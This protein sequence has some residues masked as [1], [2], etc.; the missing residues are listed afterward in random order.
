MLIWQMCYWLLIL[1][2][3]QSSQLQVDHK[4]LFPTLVTNES[5]T[6]MY[7]LI[8]CM[9]ISGYIPNVNGIV[10]H[11]FIYDQNPE[12]IF[13]YKPRVYRLLMLPNV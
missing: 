2:P 6:F 9:Y 3:E 5:L 8:D 12:I 1:G 4:Y 11:G 7:I 10:L 13:I